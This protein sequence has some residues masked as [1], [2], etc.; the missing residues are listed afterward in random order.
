MDGAR[1]LIVFYSRTGTTRQVARRMARLAGADLE[2]LVDPHERSGLG[3]YL[4]SSI[5]ATLGRSVHVAPPRHDPA[6]YDV[7]VIGT[8]VVN[9]SLAAPVRTYLLAQGGLLERV[10]FFCTHGDSGSARVIREM[11]SLCHRAPLVSLV[12]R[13][14]DVAA[15]NFDAKAHSF[16][17]QILRH[18]TGAPPSGSSSS[19]PAPRTSSSSSLPLAAPRTGARVS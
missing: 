12:L 13:T 17:G 2:E 1:A 3:G 15:A 8:P 5:D 7:V 9:S 18:V 6:L 19:W 14:P 11:E 10:A 16:M 4:K